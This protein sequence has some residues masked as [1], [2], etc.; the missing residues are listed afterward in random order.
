MIE[1]HFDMSQS[2]VDCLWNE[3]VTIPLSLELGTVALLLSLFGPFVA[4]HAVLGYFHHFPILVE[5][6]VTYYIRGFYASPQSSE[7]NWFFLS[8]EMEQL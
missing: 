8:W 7:Y 1:D 6:E 3:K 5:S 2:C 4:S